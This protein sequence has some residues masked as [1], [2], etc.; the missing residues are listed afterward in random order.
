MT[1][2]F[3]GKLIS[4]AHTGRCQHNTTIPTPM[5]SK[6]DELFLEKTSM[7]LCGHVSASVLLHEDCTVL[8][9]QGWASSSPAAE[10]STGL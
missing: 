9:A 7:F 6:G 3:K 10:L 2:T 4:V 5:A 1:K 8:Q